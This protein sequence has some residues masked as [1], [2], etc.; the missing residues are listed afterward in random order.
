MHSNQDPAQ[1]K[2][3]QTETKNKEVNWT[4]PRSQGR[5]MLNACDF[6]TIQEEQKY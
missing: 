3:K 1:P 2:N 4:C 5:L 6:I